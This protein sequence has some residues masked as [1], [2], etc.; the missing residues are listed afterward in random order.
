LRNLNFQDE[1]FIIEIEE[2]V[3]K[4]PEL[5]I[6]NYIINESVRK[7]LNRVQYLP[8]LVE[9][10]KALTGI[11]DKQISR[12]VAE[13]ESMSTVIFNNPEIASLFSV[14]EEAWRKSDFEFLHLDR[15][16]IRGTRLPNLDQDT[17]KLISYLPEGNKQSGRRQ[18]SQFLLAALEQIAAIQNKLVYHTKTINYSACNIQE[19]EG[20]E[21][22]DW[23]DLE[24]LD[25]VTEQTPVSLLVILNLI[26]SSS[27]P[28]QCGTATTVLPLGC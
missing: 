7:E 28:L 1:G 8:A 19:E 13:L 10:P 2:E 16:V 24:D 22:P 4:H 12:E 9:L 18:E 5:R 20:E 25:E 3:K 6:F 11:Y 23:T 15:K 27:M 26:L 17:N 14:F 21:V